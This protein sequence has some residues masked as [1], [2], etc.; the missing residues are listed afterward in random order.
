MRWIALILGLTAANIWAQYLP[1]QTQEVPGGSDIV[2]PLTLAPLSHDYESGYQSRLRMALTGREYKLTR[3]EGDTDIGKRDWPALLVKLWRAQAETGTVASL[4]RGPGQVLLTSRWAGSFYKPFSCPGYLMFYHEFERW[5]TPEMKAIVRS[6]WMS[7]GRDQTSRP[8]HHM[9]PIY[10]ATEYNSENFDWMARTAGALL[11]REFADHTPIEGVPADQWYQRWVDNWVRALYHIGRVEWGSDIYFGYVVQP[12]LVYFNYAG[13]PAERRKGRAALDALVLDAALHNVGGFASGPGT[14]QKGSEHHAFNG[15]TWWWTW[16]LLSSPEGHPWFSDAIAVTNTDIQMPG[17]AAFSR[18]RPPQVALD[19]AHRKFPLPVEMHNAK[20]RYS[21]DFD[22]Y[23]HWRGDHDLSRRDEWEMLWID[24]DYTLGSSAS[25][26]PAADAKP[27]TE[28]Q[29]FIEQSLWRL[30][31][32]GGMMLTG[33]AGRFNGGHYNNGRN[34]AEEIAQWR[35]VMMRL[36]KGDDQLHVIIPAETQPVARGDRIYIDCGSGVYAAFIPLDAGTVSRSAV[37]KG[38]DRYSWTFARDRVGALV[39]ETGTKESHGGFARFVDAVESNRISLRRIDRLTVEYKSSNHSHPGTLRMQW[40][41]PR[42][43]T[44]LLTG[45]TV[46]LAGNR[47]RA[48]GD[49]LE[50]D[51]DRWQVY[52]TI[53]G[54]PVMEQAWGGGRLTVLAGGQGLRIEVSADTADVAYRTFR[55]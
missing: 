48:W 26:R 11:S 39:L 54:H 23:A 9:D 33:S 15:T 14:R 18:Y 5:F 36:I 13:T 29:P 41:A 34:P 3:G 40:Q 6:R 22:N 50:F 4:V 2:D 38:F 19:L 52:H 7:I 35:T 37:E 49:G 27:D 21:G 43:F 31:V 12:A 44:W 24:K 25:F 32:R 28:N 53:Y 10:P 30:T 51:W 8:D 17:L 47:A 42:E 16:L 1:E 45:K 46:S 20:V 55:E